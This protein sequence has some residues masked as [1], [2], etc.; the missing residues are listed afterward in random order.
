[1]RNLVSHPVES[2]KQNL[3]E[4]G[5]PLR[6]RSGGNSRIGGFCTAPATAMGVCNRGHKGWLSWINRWGPLYCLTRS[7]WLGGW[8]ITRNRTGSPESFRIWWRLLGAIW[9]PSSAERRI[10]SPST[11]IVA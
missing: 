4:I 5:F 3:T 10:V 8:E 7:P 2:F 9:T 11:S 6:E 1:V